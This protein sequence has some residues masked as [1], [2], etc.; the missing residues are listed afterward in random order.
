MTPTTTRPRAA[1]CRF[2]AALEQQ[3]TQAQLHEGE[4]WYLVS[5]P[6]WK[7]VLGTPRS[8]ESDGQTDDDSDDE[9]GFAREKG[10]FAVENA[11]LLE[12][13]LSSRERHVT[14]LRSMLVRA[15]TGL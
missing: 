3:L 11:A 13:D 4:A 14:V 5:I 10:D 1:L 8:D 15:S 7:R 6:W 12:L 9:A 2:A